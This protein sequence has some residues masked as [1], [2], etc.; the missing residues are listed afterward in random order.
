[1]LALE[2]R[3]LFDA[4]ALTVAGEEFQDSQSIEPA[5]DMT[6]VEA[7]QANNNNELLQAAVE[8]GTPISEESVLTRKGMIDDEV[9][10][11]D[12]AELE[13]ADLQIIQIETE[14]DDIQQT[15]TAL[16]EQVADSVAVPIPPH[17]NEGGLQPQ[18]NIQTPSDLQPEAI[19]QWEND[20]QSDFTVGADI[21]HEADVVVDPTGSVNETSQSRF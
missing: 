15:T 13:S 8:L 2:P 20:W 7:P 10:T 17:A 12:N 18:S 1:M 5:V 14:Q 4:A 9:P 11:A 6:I 3:I 16:S 21:S 19:V